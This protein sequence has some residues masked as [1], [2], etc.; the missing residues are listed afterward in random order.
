MKTPKDWNEITVSQYYNLL[1]AIEMDF[2]DDLDKSVAMLSALTN[3][4]IK[5]LEE[6]IPIKD[7][8]KGLKDIAF[9]G[10]QRPKPY[11]NPRI[12]LNGKKYEFDMVLRESVA[13]SFIDFAEL[14]K[15]PKRNIHKIL[16]IF[17]HE[18]DWKGARVKKTI[19]NQIELA[20][21]IERNM[22]MDM[23]FGYSDFFLNSWERL[24][25]ATA[26]YLGKVNKKHK[27]MIAKELMELQNL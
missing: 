24:Q 4:S 16:A 26:G 6:K 7:L 22:T 23:A 25:K 15:E 9:I 12:K 17:M 8:T 1:E 21:I 11:L 18:L 10:K 2:D 13:G 5:D 27:K 3:I 19:K 14:S 20:N